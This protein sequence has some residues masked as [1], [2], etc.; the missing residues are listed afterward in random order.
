MKAVM[1][2]RKILAERL[3][4]QSFLMADNHHVVLSLSRNRNLKRAMETEA[5]MQS[6]SAREIQRNTGLYFLTSMGIPPLE[7]LQD[8]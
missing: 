7:D 5:E 8:T 4:S 3:C 2:N 6:V 1:P